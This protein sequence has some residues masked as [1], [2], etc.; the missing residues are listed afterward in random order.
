MEG[1]LLETGCQRQADAAAE[2]GSGAA[3]EDAA[4]ARAEIRLRAARRASVRLSGLSIPEGLGAH[5]GRGPTKLQLSAHGGQF[6][7]APLLT[8]R[9]GGKQDQRRNE[10]S[11]Y[12]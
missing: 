1:K 8:P 6:L 7:S 12:G 9:G 4:P 10:I 5:P 3:G 2:G 11:P